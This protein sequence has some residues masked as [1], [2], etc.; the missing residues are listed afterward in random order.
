MLSTLVVLG[1]SRLANSKIFTLPLRMRLMSCKCFKK[2]LVLSMS[3]T[4]GCNGVT[5]AWLSL[6]SNS[7]CSPD[8]APGASTIRKSKSLGASPMAFSWRQSTA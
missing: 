4:E 3:K 7:A 2:R 8:K 5:M 1:L 6:T